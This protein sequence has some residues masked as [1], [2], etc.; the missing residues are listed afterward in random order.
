MGKDSQKVPK[1]PK[2]VSA[3]EV[4]TP[5]VIRP[6]FKIDDETY[7]FD[8]KFKPASDLTPE[9]VHTTAEL[10]GLIEKQAKEKTK[11]PV[12]IDAR[13]LCYNKTK[14]KFQIKRYQ[15]T[16]KLMEAVRKTD[17]KF[18]L[19]ES[20]SRKSFMEFD[21]WFGADV[22]TGGREDIND[23]TPLLGGPFFKQLYQYDYMRMHSACF[24]AWHHD[25][26]AKFIIEV[27]HDFCLGKGFTVESDDDDSQK[28]WDL[29]QEANDFEKRVGNF[30][31][32]LT[33]YGEHFVWFLPGMD[34]KI[35]F[36]P[37][38]PGQP[39]K[40]NIP[41]VRLID[42]SAIWDICTMPDDIEQVLFYQWIAPTQYQTYTAPGVPTTKFIFQQIPA[43][44]VLHYKIN[45]ADDEK[46]GRSELFAILGYL[47]RLRDSINY[48]VISMQKA[49]AWS[50][51]T[52]IEGSQ[53]D[54]EA[55]AAAQV[56]LGTVPPAGSE[57]I[58]TKAVAREYLDNKAGGGHR[59][60]TFEWVL[61]AIAAGSRIPI[62]YFGTHLSG[63]GTRGN[64]V[65]A[66][67]PVAKFFESRRELVKQMIMDVHERITG[68]DCEVR[69]PELITQDRSQKIRDTI[70]IYQEEIFSKER[71]SSIIAE[72]MQQDEF[73]YDQEQAQIRSEPSPIM[74]T[75]MGTPLTAPPKAA[76]TPATPNS[77]LNG[78]QKAG[79]KT[80][81]RT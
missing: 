79:I 33:V 24:Y 13:V 4:G 69:F 70:S 67:E 18:K 36:K 30:L 74:P 53:S 16:S 45:H 63:H 51:D 11:N 71:A 32:E 21:D 14:K 6:S 19:R 75:T 17:A 56:T 43:D 78:T 57:F 68:K 66:T 80:N 44:N 23:F 25:P 73:E 48:S 34:S 1:I 39:A 58:H 40:G 61:S 81:D 22:G 41:R 29:F 9:S 65:V 50:I 27:I 46:R 10:F 28:Q 2:K 60:E 37:Y 49:A 38:A 62:Q 59:S 12:E 15:E 3:L 77:G 20:K 47:K 72:E 52:T 76:G 54:L 7:A 31:R 8:D 55:Y 35:A 26:F 42:P 5:K 64:A